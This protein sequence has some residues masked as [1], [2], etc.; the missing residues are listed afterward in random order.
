M[1]R[2]CRGLWQDYAVDYGKISYD[3]GKIL[4][5]YCK[6]LQDHWKVGFTEMVSLSCIGFS[7]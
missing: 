6:I 4:L 1:A 7:F 3:I 2:L 5:D